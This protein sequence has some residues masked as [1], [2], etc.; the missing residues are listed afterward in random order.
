MH[1]YGRNAGA[2]INIVT[3]SGTN[4]LHGSAAEYFR[5]D[6]LDARNFFNP[7]PNPKTSFHNN[8]FGGSLGGPIV[9]DKTFFFA[10][11]EGQRETGGLNSLSCVPTQQ[12]I[13]SAG[14]ATNPVTPALLRPQPCQV[15]EL[16]PAA[17]HNASA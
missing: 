6:A 15:P 17:C 8:Q 13:A 10:D 14:G 3:K 4:T 11:Y 9:R 16:A 7:A 5:N 1:E 12:Q 2:V